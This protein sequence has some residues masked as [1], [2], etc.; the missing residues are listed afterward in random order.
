MAGAGAGVVTVVQ[1]ACPVVYVPCPAGTSIDDPW[2]W[3]VWV[4]AVAKT[5]SSKTRS[6]VRMM[7]AS[8][9]E[10]CDTGEGLHGSTAKTPGVK[11][12]HYLF[13]QAGRSVA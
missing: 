5:E 11:R 6:A 10:T 3:V 2:Q 1:L 13:V 4:W 8:I 9:L 7:G 12:K